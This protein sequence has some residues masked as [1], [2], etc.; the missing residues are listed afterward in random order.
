MMF[1]KIL[2][3]AD[4]S[5]CARDAALIAAQVA[6]HFEAEALLL[7]VFDLAAHGMLSEMGVWSL[8]LGEDIV[9]DC[10]KAER[11]SVAKHI[12]PLFAAKGVACQ[13]L[14]ETGHPVSAIVQVAEREK[15][16][17]IVIGSRELRGLK[18][19]FLGSVSSGVLHHAPCS[20][21]IV[22]GEN[23]L[24]NPAG[25]EHILLASDGSEGAR[26]GTSVAMAMAQKFV[27]SLTVLNV[28]KPVP[29]LFVAVQADGS[30]GANG[31][32]QPERYAAHLLDSV[33]QIT[34]GSALEAR[35]QWDIKQEEGHP[36]ETIVRIA[37]EKPSDMIIIGSRGLG[38]FAE[39]L[40]GSVSNY[41][42]HHA[43]C[44]VL[45]VR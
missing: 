44:P 41:V 19:K 27:A 31:G 25:F 12:A 20:V 7:N 23:A 3:C 33:R 13:V 5:A 14:Q 24:R 17:L 2:V 10:A 6:A 22:R 1:K 29:F 45:V 21:L 43:N 35:V 32:L 28:F 38:G 40:L 15:A 9:E 34:Q 11:E 37:E 30:E 42:A 36:A 16:D 4:D 39:M 8:T 18:E 26:R